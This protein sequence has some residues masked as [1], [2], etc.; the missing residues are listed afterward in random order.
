[1]GDISNGMTKDIPSAG[2]LFVSLLKIFL[3][4]NISYY[5]QSPIFRLLVPQP[6]WIQI[7][8]NINANLQAY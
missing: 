2:E 7:S 8:T 4:C 1:M 3:Y 5:S 6:L